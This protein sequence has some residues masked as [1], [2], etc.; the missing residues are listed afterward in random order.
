MP[1]RQVFLSSQGLFQVY[2]EIFPISVTEGLLIFNKTGRLMSRRPF[3]LDGVKLEMVRSYKYLGFVITPSGEIRDR[4]FKAF[5]K[6]KNDIPIT[7]KLLDFLVK[8][9]LLYAGN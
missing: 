3:Y 6:I 1:I 5:M 7:L 8:P 2:F 9:I 4:A